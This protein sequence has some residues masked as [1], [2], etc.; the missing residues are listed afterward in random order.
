MIDFLVAFKLLQGISIYIEIRPPQVK[1]TL[2]EIF[3]FTDAPPHDFLGHLIDERVFGPRCINDYL[4][5][6]DDGGSLI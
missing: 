3:L 2:K 1:I 5:L 6:V 4:F